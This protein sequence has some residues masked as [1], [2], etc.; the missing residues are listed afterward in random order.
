MTVRAM[1]MKMITS[2]THNGAGVPI[3]HRYNEHDSD[4]HL[5]FCYDAVRPCTQLIPIRL[6][7]MAGGRGE[8]HPGDSGSRHICPSHSD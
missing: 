4:Q 7:M 2:D 3:L 5:F 6:C 8:M 1:M